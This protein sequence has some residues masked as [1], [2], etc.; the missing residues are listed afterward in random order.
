MSHI[1]S[2]P[3][4]RSRAR[5]GW[6]MLQTGQ[7]TNMRMYILHNRVFM[8]SDTY[9]QLQYSHLGIVGLSYTGTQACR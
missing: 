8:I 4:T 2:L 7:S 6:V 5:D 1:L 9:V 3:A